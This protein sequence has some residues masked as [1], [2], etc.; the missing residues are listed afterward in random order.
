MGWLGK[1][2]GTDKAINNLVDKDDGLLAKAGSWIGAFNYTDEEKAEADKETR[3]WGLRQLEALAPFKVVQRI[4]FFTVCG[5]WVLMIIN[6]LLA[7]WFQHPAK[8]EILQFAFSDF[9]FWPTVAVFS[10]YY[11]GGVFPRKGGN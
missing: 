3:E 1:L 11:T 7:V 4:G 8:E 5:V 10:L 9:I 6:V 2:F